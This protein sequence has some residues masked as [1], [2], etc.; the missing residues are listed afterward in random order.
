MSKLR[1]IS[2]VI[3][4]FGLGISSASAQLILVDDNRFVE[5]DSDSYGSSSF[6]GLRNPTAEFAYFRATEG[7]STFSASQTSSIGLWSGS[8][9]LNTYGRSSDENPYFGTVESVYD[10]TFYADS[11]STLDFNG[12]ARSFYGVNSSFELFENGVSL[13]SYS[14]PA[15]GSGTSG[16][17]GSTSFADS[18][19]L[20]SGNLYQMVASVSSQSPGSFGNSPQGGVLLDW[21]F[22]AVPEPSAAFLVLLSVAGFGLRRRR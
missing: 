8:A 4:T 11:G 21:T 17:G 22:E 2:V 9:D 10:F 7:I 5:A 18:V 3:V 20:S 12:V 19:I 6:V 15:A 1:I 14:G 13:F 16:S